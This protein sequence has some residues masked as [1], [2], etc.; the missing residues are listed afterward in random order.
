MGRAEDV[1]GREHDVLGER[2]AGDLGGVER[3]QAA[4]E[5]DAACGT[6]QGSMPRASAR[7]PSPPRAL[8]RRTAQRLQVLAI[9]AVARRR[10]PARRDGLGPPEKLVAILKVDQPLDPVGPRGDVAAADRGRKRLGEAA[11]ADHAVEPVERGKARRRLGLEIGEDVVLD[12]GQAVLVGELQN[13][14]GD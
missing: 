2:R 6:I 9:A 7:R 5:V 3:R 10:G 11:D 4:P 14:V 13:P 8:A 1:A 12:D